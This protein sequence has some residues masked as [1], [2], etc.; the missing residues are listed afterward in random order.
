MAFFGRLFEKYIQNL[1]KEAAKENYIYIDEFSY[2]KNNKKSS[3]AYIR[4]NNNL[5][6]IEVKGF[7]VLIDCMTKNE[8]VEKNNNKMFAS[9]IIQADNCL[10]RVIGN[11]E[12]FTGIEEAYIISVT[13]DNINAV[14]DYYNEIH[15]KIETEK[16][17][18]KTKYYFNF[19]IEEYEM[20][21]YLVEQQQDIFCLLKEYY[22][23]E[24]LKPFNNYLLEKYPK[25]GMT[26][27]MEILYQEASE[28]MKSMLYE[29]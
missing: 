2:G 24:K 14:P 4:K 13:M 29:E 3:D 15:K 17:C 1:T 18:E 19:N 20:L 26:S 27:F 25:I 5:L 12:E 10:T 7:S 28:K 16:K 22:E 21:M 11:K 6:A 9:P 23:N 8:K